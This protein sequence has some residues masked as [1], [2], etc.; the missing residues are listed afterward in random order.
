MIKENLREVER[1]IELACK[2]AGRDQSEVTLV[3]VSKTKPGGEC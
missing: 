2:K 3:A 1:E